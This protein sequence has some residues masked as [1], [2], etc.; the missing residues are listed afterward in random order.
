MDKLF[1]KKSEVQVIQ[2]RI[3]DNL[4]MRENIQKLE[5]NEELIKQLKVEIKT[6]SHDSLAAQD[7]ECQTSYEELISE[8]KVC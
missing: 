7:V 6:Y 8:V 5:L 3:K 4:M 2:R 1:K